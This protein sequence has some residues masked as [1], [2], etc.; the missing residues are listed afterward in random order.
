[1]PAFACSGTCWFAC[2]VC[3]GDCLFDIF[4]LLGG[5]VRS[6][7]FACWVACWFAILLVCLVLFAGGVL[8]CLLLLAGE[9]VGSFAFA[10]WRASWFCLLG[11]KK[12]S[13]GRL[14]SRSLVSCLTPFACFAPFPLLCFAFLCCFASFPC[15]ACLLACSSACLLACLLPFR[16]LGVSLLSHHHCAFRFPCCPGLR[17]PGGLKRFKRVCFFVFFSKSFFL[18][19]WPPSGASRGQLGR[20]WGPTWPPKR[21][22]NLCF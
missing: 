4:C 2:F 9:F 14:L 19:L 13:R 5:L 6:L 10:C 21:S 15:A 11:A 7:A 18:H 8:A 1:M 20:F 12:P 17:A 22:Q 3:W 16:P